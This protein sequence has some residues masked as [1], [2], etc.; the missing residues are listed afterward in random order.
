MDKNLKL[1]FGIIIFAVLIGAT[2]IGVSPYVAAKNNN[3]NGNGNGNN[4][5]GNGNNKSGNATYI[6]CV[7]NSALVKNTC[8]NTS[9][10]VGAACR[11]DAKNATGNKNTTE[12]I[13]KELKKCNTAYIKDQKQCLKDFKTTKK[14]TCKKIK[15]SWM[16]EVFMSKE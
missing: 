13:N 15:H 7:T 3:S 1:I 5:N 4:G 12:K 14:S 10:S 16:D 11:I 2:I 9:K 8:F 6:S